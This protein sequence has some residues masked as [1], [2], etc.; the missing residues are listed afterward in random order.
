[1]SP[2]HYCTGDV[3]YLIS[4]KKPIPGFAID[5]VAVNYTVFTICIFFHMENVNSANSGDVDIRNLTVT[6]IRTVVWG[7]GPFYLGK[8]ARK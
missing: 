7:P 5:I 6:L 3:V 8:L 4:L 1:V 2:T